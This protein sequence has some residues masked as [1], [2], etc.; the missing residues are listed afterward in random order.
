MNQTSSR[1]YGNIQSS[2]SS[3]I[4]SSSLTKAHSKL[5]QQMPQNEFVMEYPCQPKDSITYDING[6]DLDIKEHQILDSY[7]NRSK[8]QHSQSMIILAERRKI[9]SPSIKKNKKK[10]KM[11]QIIK[12]FIEKIKISNNLYTKQPYVNTLLQTYSIPFV[13]EKAN[14]LS[15]MD[16]I[17]QSIR[18]PIPRQCKLRQFWKL[19]MQITYLTT[20]IFSPLILIYPSNIY[21]QAL[22]FT[23]LTLLV[24][25][26]ILN[27]N[28]CFYKNGV[29]VTHLPTIQL[30][31]LRRY[32]LQDIIQYLSFIFILQF[33][34]QNQ[35]ISII[36]LI[37]LNLLIIR[38]IKLNSLI[39]QQNS[40]ILG[41]Q[42]VK[43]LAYCH[44][45]SL[46]SISYNEDIGLESINVQLKY[47]LSYLHEYINEYLTLQSCLVNSTNF[48]LLISFLIQIIFTFN[49]VKLILDLLFYF[50]QNVH[51]YL[52]KKNYLDLK[53][54]LQNHQV[55]QN[56]MKKALSNYKFEM[57]KDYQQQNFMMDSQSIKYIDYEIQKA[58]QNTVNTKYF[59][60]I[61]VLGQFS[62]NIQEK[63][64]ENMSIQYF[65]PNEIILRQN[66]K[67]DDSIYLIKKGQVK[68]CY[69]S[70]NK[71]QFGI[72]SLGEMQTFGEV[73][74]FTGLPRTSTIVSLGPVE[75]YKISR[76]DFLESI[77]N[78]RQDLEIAT[79][80]KDQILQNNQYGLIGL[81]CFCCKSKE[82]LI[83]QCDKLHYKP[84]KE[85]IIS[86][87]Q[88]A[89]LQSRRQYKRSHRRTNNTREHL[90]QI[91]MA[92]EEFQENNY[93]L[94]D[95]SEILKELTQNYNFQSSTNIQQNQSQAVGLFPSRER[96]KSVDK[97]SILL[98]SEIDDVREQ[99][100]ELDPMV[101]KKDKGHFPS[102]NNF[103]IK[104]VIQ[105]L[106]GEDSSS[107]SNDTI[108]NDICITHLQPSSDKQKQNT[109][110]LTIPDKDKL[111][112]MLIINPNSQGQQVNSSCQIQHSQEMKNSSIQNKKSLSQTLLH[113]QQNDFTKK[114]D[115]LKSPSRQAYYDELDLNPLD[116]SSPGMK[117]INKSPQQNKAKIEESPQIFIDLNNNS[118]HFFC[119]EDKE[120]L[121]KAQNYIYYYPYFNP[122][123]LINQQLIWTNIRYNHFKIHR[124]QKYV[125]KSPY[126]ISYVIS[127]KIKQKAILK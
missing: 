105:E 112:E 111:Q 65:Q 30:N 39:S 18:L 118:S 81:K 1:E 97:N 93:F 62:Q 53:S 50:H 101:Y 43:G 106:E 102:N 89:H 126:T 64:V 51:K 68:V 99:F 75:T 38:L 60:K 44:F 115:N 2:N 80:M 33:C 56:L 72:K 104:E 122:E 61:L 76:S 10:I 28:T 121:D 69:Q 123:F 58:I 15:V 103:P 26:S 54:Y 35:Q 83:F 63:L 27:L 59:K 47:Y 11:E 46:I 8:Q 88:Y 57:K 94:E 49:R 114:N 124:I 85:K 84:D 22:L 36:A 95:Q 24:F 100:Q 34:E 29:E 23:Q 116:R 31:Y 5:Q 82:H 67:D 78:N 125:K 42:F 12:K 91:G 19:L 108:P 20:V 74:F 32:G 117:K 7:S 119:L 16:K 6:I 90:F 52:L 14:N 92:G 86:K 79:Y 25:N 110:L 48:E 21:I 41:W 66:C 73:S 120:E 87:Y 98:I 70:G 17:K 9:T 37:I 4:Q 13:K 45:F 113:V 109:N 55:D 71:K 77:K 96:I 127:D 107:N 40:I 3:R